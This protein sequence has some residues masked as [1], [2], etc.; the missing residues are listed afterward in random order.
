MELDAL[1][2]LLVQVK[3][4]D[5]HLCAGEPPSMRVQRVIRRTRAPELTGEDIAEILQRVA[6][7]ER[8][9]R[10]R[11]NIERLHRKWLN[12]VEPDFVIDSGGMLAEVRSGR[13]RPYRRNA[14]S[15]EAPSPV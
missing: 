2:A 12:K 13:I 15:P 8:F 3:G 6:G 11:E 9:R 14:P 5:L 10:V 1:L 4:S 7:P